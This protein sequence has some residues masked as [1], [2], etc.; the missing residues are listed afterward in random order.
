MFLEDLSALQ[1]LST[2]LVKE[3]LPEL[4]NF[5]AVHMNKYYQN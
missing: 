2:D 1:K 3:N 4:S 5:Q